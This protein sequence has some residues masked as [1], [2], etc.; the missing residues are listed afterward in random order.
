MTVPT[1][2]AGRDVAI[3]EDLVEE[4]GRIHGY[5]KIEAEPLLGALQPVDEEPARAARREVRRVLSDEQGFT[6][7]FAYPFATADE[8]ARAQV[9]PGTLRLAN[10]EQPG[11]DLMATSLVPKALQ[12]LADNLRYRDEIAM[13]LVAPV[14]AEREGELP[15]ETERLV[16]VYASGEEAPVLTAKRAVEA[17][18]DTLRVNGARLTQQ[19]GPG[20]LHPGRCARLGRG[21]MEFG[22][23]GEI[24][25]AV[26][27]AYDIDGR[28]ALADL[29]LSA[30]VAARG[31]EAKMAAISKFPGVRYD[32]SLLVDRKTP[33]SD[34]AGALRSVDKKLVRSVELF[35]EY[36][37]KN[38]P[39]DKR[40]LA[41]AIEFGAMDRTLDTKDVERLRTAVSTTVAKRGWELR[42]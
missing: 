3:P 5:A 8:C 36:R 35:D 13:Y 38:V 21:K 2:R 17:L 31:K 34:V 39:D 20:Y 27:R 7:F 16:L 25:P 14:F 10:A 15:L 4:V 32:V 12:V 41:F 40:S 23:V 9:E 26:R 19:E 42:A 18:V 1:W 22:W 37:G 33:A 24:H 11:L 6:E 28:A 29:D 30:L